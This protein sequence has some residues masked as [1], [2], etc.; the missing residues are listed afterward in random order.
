MKFKY[1]IPF[2]IFIVLTPIITYFM[3]N[4]QVWAPY[5]KEEMISVIGLC[6][7][8]F[9]VGVTYFSGIRAVMKDKEESNKK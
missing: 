7:M 6:V 5:P 3:W 8:W 9:F 1:W 2:F 4:P